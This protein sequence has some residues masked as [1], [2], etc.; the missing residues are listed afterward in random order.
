MLYIIKHVQIP[1]DQLR[2][3]D[4]SGIVKLSCLV[5]TLS[6]VTDISILHS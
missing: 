2:F 3:L 6:C 4:W 5:D 1:K